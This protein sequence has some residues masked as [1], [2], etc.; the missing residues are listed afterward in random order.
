[1]TLVESVAVRLFREN[2]H[3]PR[4]YFYYLVAYDSTA[5]KSRATELPFPS[6]QEMEAITIFRGT[7]CRIR[8]IY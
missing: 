1:V 5:H 7:D 4:D 2:G 3:Q 6:L 8:G